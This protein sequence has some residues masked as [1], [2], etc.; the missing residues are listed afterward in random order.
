MTVPLHNLSHTLSPHS[1]ARVRRQIRPDAQLRVLYFYL[2]VTTAAAQ[3][4]A[5]SVCG[6][7]AY[8]RATSR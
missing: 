2:M 8:G 7:A 6:S 4:A 3:S 1:V 5:S